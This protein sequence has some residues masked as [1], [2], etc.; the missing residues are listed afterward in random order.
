MW[1]AESKMRNR[2]CGTTLIGRS[3]KP[4]DHCLS[5]YYHNAYICISQ[6]AEW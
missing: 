2:K 5:A 3:S 6:S 1:N 4:R